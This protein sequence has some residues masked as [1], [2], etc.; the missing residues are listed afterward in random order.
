MTRLRVFLADDHPVVLAGIKALL[1]ADPDLEIVGAARDGQT[2]LR[3]ARD[4]KPDVVVLDLSMP[5]MNGIDLARHLR[6]ECPACKVLA[7]TVHE[8]RSYVRKLLEVGAVGYVLKRSAS[9]DLLRAIHAVAAGG[10]YLDPAIAGQAIVGAADG[11]H[12]V[13]P[14]GVELSDREVE[15]LRLTA[16][17]H[18][19]KAI[20]GILGI[21]VKSVETYKARAMEKLGFG[22]R[23]ELVGYALTQGWLAKG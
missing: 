21:G 23:V 14:G 15:V 19:N 8:D 2:A 16:V 11:P 18:S 22:N 20:A 3:M 13:A 12:D 4:L 9:E 10:L 1:Q 5:A 6:T 7:L 17:G